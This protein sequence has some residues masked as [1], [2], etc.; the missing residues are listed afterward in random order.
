MALGRWIRNSQLWRSIFRHPAPVDRR[1][2][3]AVI[4]TNLIL[5]LHP[6]AIRKHAVRLQFTWC[7]GGI[8]F[9]LFLV[10]T[11]TG[12]LLMFYYR[13]TVEWAYNDMLALRDVVSFGVIRE[14][15]RWGAHAMVIAVMLHMLRVFLTGSYKPPREFNWVVGVML[16]VLTFLLS[17]TGYLLPWDQLS[18]WA[19]TVGSNMLGAAPFLGHEGPGQQALVLGGKELIT[20][21]SDVRFM[22]LGA[23]SVSEE[24]LNRFYILHCVAL[25]LVAGFL[26]GVHF[27]RVRKDGGISG[28]L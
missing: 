17:F 26:M 6:V 23:R 14:I 7:M 28:P 8:T 22:L 4:L 1:N 5:H 10:E 25:P 11:V 9:F 20:P 3:V 12:V 21:G 16:L 15:H 18:M 27:W 24:T 19:V 2:R 13:P